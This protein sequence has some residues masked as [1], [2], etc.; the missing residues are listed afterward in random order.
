M[1]AKHS[2]IKED[3]TKFP[4]WCGYLPDADALELLKNKNEFMLRCLENDSLSLT[5]YGGPAKCT[6]QAIILDRLEAP[7]LRPQWLL[8]SAKSGL[9][10]NLVKAPMELFIKV[11]WCT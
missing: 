11:S 6:K 4:F 1:G 5:L 9:E 8:S 3:H 10:T 7:I 2:N